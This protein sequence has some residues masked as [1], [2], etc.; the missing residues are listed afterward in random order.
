MELESAR[1]D[2]YACLYM[3]RG[4]PHRSGT[5]VSLTTDQF[6]VGRM[7]NDDIPDLAFSNAF[8]S[9]KH[10]MIRR[11]KGKAI[12]YDL[13]SRHGTEINGV[14]IEPYT[15]HKLQSFDIIKLAKG[16]VVIHFSYLFADQTLEFEPIS[17]TQQWQWKLPDSG[18][19]VNW[20]KHECYVDGQR[21]VMSD[22]EYGLIKVLND[23]ANQLVSF[24]EIKRKVW[25]ERSVGIDGIPDVSMDELNALIYRIRKKYGKDTFTISAVR[26]SGYVL[27]KD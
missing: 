23:Y 20:E 24:D 19:P 25:P 8:I 7:T 3:I 14:R 13:G 1:Q 5:C 22:K 11:E 17:H 6:S 9:R 15:S 2:S 21:I 10:F 4:E 18:F 26:G 16:M 27:E 12:L